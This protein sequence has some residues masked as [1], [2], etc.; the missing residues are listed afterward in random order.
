MSAKK[1]KTTPKKGKNVLKKTLPE[2]I[3]AVVLILVIGLYYYSIPPFSFDLGIGLK[4]K[5]RELSGRI[6]AERDSE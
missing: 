3:I 4:Y 2:I 1:K 5:P 6:R